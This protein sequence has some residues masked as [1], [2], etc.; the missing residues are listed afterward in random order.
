MRKTA[1]A[2]LCARVG[3]R[4]SC[5]DR[6][7]DYVVIYMFSILSKISGI[8][9]LLNYFE[10]KT[11]PKEEDILNTTIQ[12]GTIRYRRCA[13]IFMD[14]EGLYLSAKMIFKSYPVIFI[15]WS[16][17]KETKK[18]KLYGRKAIQLDFKDSTLPS[19]KIYETDFRGNYYNLK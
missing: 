19:I 16:S 6:L 18:E 11:F 9:K 12:V 17:I 10:S 13:L 3:K 15:P 5:N 1:R 14:N 4:H 7:K 8:S 2:G